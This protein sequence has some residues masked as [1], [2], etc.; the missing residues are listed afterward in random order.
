MTAKCAIV[1]TDGTL[2]FTAIFSQAPGLPSRYEM[3][4]GIGCVWNR[5]MMPARRFRAALSH[6]RVASR[7]SNGPKRPSDF[8]GGNDG[9]IV[10]QSPNRR[11]P[12]E[13]ATAGR[14]TVHR[15]PAGRTNLVWAGSF[16]F[17]CEPAVV[18]QPVLA[19]QR[20]HDRGASGRRPAFGS[21]EPGGWSD[22]CSSLAS[23]GRPVNPE[24]KIPNPKS[25]GASARSLTAPERRTTRGRATTCD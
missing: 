25:A 14:R 18:N 17:Q 22:D 9:P 2:R 23:S 21:W 6:V 15:E 13:K 7:K 4:R 11:A 10:P 20:P 24:S 16:E 1:G 3:S 8:Q 12:A 5:A 19:G